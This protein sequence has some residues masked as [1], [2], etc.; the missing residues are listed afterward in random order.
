FTRWTDILNGTAMSFATDVPAGSPL[1][2]SLNIPWVGGGVNNGGHLYKK[3]SPGVDDT[4]YIR[5][6]IKYP[7]SGAFS[8]NGIWAGGYNPPLDWPNPQAGTKP[9][10]NDRFSAAAE[11]N[12][13]T[14]RFDHYD[15]W[16]D[17]HQSLDNNYWGNVLLNKPS[18]VGKTAQWMCVEQMIKLNNPVTASNGEQAI[19]LDGVKISHLGQGF[20]NGFWSGGNFTQDPTGS[21]F[22]GFRLRSDTALN[23]N[24]IW[25]E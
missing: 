22:V 15:Y 11:Q 7:A 10:G 4:L 3:L 21:P 18:V 13:S 16:M 2:R 12:S 25:P 19:W 20:P 8:H 17:M 9:A 5:Y 23:L 6:Y 14:T 1:T 24:Y